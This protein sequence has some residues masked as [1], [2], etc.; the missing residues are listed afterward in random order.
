MVK[1][2]LFKVNFIKGKISFHKTYCI[3]LIFSCTKGSDIEEYPPVA[4]VQ[5]FPLIGDTTTIFLADASTSYDE[6]YPNA[7]LE[8]QWNWGENEEWSGYSINQT[9]TYKYDSF[10]S[11]M[12]SVRVIDSSGW[13]DTDFVEIMVVEDK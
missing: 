10:G 13:T 2:C 1:K 11:Y 4:Q 5:V 6:N 3:S 7:C 12:V 9:S 8:F